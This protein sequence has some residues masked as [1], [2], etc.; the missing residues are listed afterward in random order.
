MECARETG[1]IIFA[2]VET[3]MSK[4][5]GF[6]LLMSFAGLFSGVLTAALCG[7]RF[8]NSLGIPFGAI[9]AFCFAAS[10]V[11]R[12]VSKLTCFFLATACSFYISVFSAVEADL[13]IRDLLD[14]VR[15]TAYPT[16]YF[17]GGAIGGFL[18]LGGAMILTERSIGLRVI[19][20]KAFAWSLVAGALAPIAWALGPSLG[21]WVWSALHTA[22]V[23]SPMNTFSNALFGETGYGPP[24][25]LFALFV[26]WQTGVSFALGM[27]LRNVRETPEKF[28]VEELKLT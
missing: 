12:S 1:T 6:V 14:A 26:I 15:S 16:S 13:A 23:T 7:D 27:I 22:G 5:V 4:G 18:V 24:S 9:M 2:G 20:R 3:Y 10:G 25:S 17:F 11:T 8:S 21:M 28:P 19:G